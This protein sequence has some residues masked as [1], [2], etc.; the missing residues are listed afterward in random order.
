MS[1][2]L[3]SCMRGLQLSVSRLGLSLAATRRGLAT[4]AEAPSE[5][6]KRAA[7]E[8]RAQ[9]RLRKLKRFEQG[10]S[11]FSY[12]PMAKPKGAHRQALLEARRNKIAK[13]QRLHAE[14]RKEKKDATTMIPDKWL[15]GT[16][17]I[18]LPNLSLV[19]LRNNPLQRPYDP[20]T[21]TF[22][23]APTLTKIDIVNYL[24]AVY[25]LEVTSI[26]TMIES[27]ARHV[28]RDRVQ[29]KMARRMSMQPYREGKLRN[30]RSKKVIVS[31][32]QP[33]WYPAPRSD[34]FMRPRFQ[35]RQV[36]SGDPNRPN[37]AGARSQAGVSQA[38]SQ[39]KRT[40]LK[41]VQKRWAEED[42]NVRSF[43]ER[44][45]SVRSEPDV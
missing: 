7:K 11:T 38:E 35:T 20:Y 8:Q 4:H 40:Y 28:I 23:C 5:G 45:K 27:N 24:A 33:F 30:V 44:A 41:R 9:D 31:L 17:E 18:Y 12:K 22:R 19:M 16:R 3:C 21:A 1:A 34:D 26:R 6:A 39:N 37:L 14:R 43:I 32:K 36:D 13:L 29:A 42:K 10:G 2:R 25:K 15:Q